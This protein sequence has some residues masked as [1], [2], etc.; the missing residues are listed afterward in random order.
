MGVKVE[1]ARENERVRFEP[2]HSV[3]HGRSS[4]LDAYDDGIFDQNINTLGWILWE[5]TT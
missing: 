2:G 3:A 5:K 4:G 1:Q